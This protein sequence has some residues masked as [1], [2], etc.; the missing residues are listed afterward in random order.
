MSESIANL[1][2]EYQGI[3]AHVEAAEKKFSEW[4]KPFSQRQEQI[5]AAITAEMTQQ[6]LKSVK[7]DWGTPILSEITS[8]KIKPE[9]RDAYIDWCLENWDQYGGEMLQIMAP[10]ADAVRAYQDANQGQLP[11]HVETSVTFRFSIRKS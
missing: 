7:T 4:R 10:K 11:P 9:E 1:V 6:G 8:A 5:Q 2:K 3:K